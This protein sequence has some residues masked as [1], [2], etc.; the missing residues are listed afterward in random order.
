MERENKNKKIE[1]S[2][3]MERKK[4]TKENQTEVTV[5][6]WYEKKIKKKKMVFRRI[7]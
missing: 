5:K 1:E 7:K 6:Q 3:K 4:M 2:M